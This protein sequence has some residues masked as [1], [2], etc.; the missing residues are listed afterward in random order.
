M[1]TCVTA[2]TP[3]NLVA[4][5]SMFG[6]VAQ[7]CLRLSRRKSLGH[8]VPSLGRHRFGRRGNSVGLRLAEGDEAAAQAIWERYFDRL[9]KLCDQ[10]ARRTA[11]TSGRRGR[12]GA[13]RHNSF[14]K[15]MAAGAIQT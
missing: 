6:L 14:C 2:Q 11:V 8:Q 4:N 12:R 15:A 9:A 1:I 13:M 5:L 3:L 10:E 7:A